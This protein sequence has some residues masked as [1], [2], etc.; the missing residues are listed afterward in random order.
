[1]SLSLNVL[2]TSSK[3]VL[4]KNQNPTL[5][6][7]SEIPLC[8]AVLMPC[9]RIFKRNNSH[10]ISIS[11][12]K[13]LKLLEYSI[14][15]VLKPCFQISRTNL[16]LIIK[17][18]SLNIQVKNFAEKM[19]FNLAY[20]VINLTLIIFPQLHKTKIFFVVVIMIIKIPTLGLN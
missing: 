8:T 13:I 10:F 7:C 3:V 20:K 12:S 1:M 16:Y 17:I 18:F 19:Y 2:L 6:H 11:S 14:V 15:P 5:P 9:F 4:T